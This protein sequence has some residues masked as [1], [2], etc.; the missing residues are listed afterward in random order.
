MHG[1]AFLNGSR[2]GAGRPVGE[3]TAKRTTISPP[4]T[5]ARS[6]ACETFWD[7]GIRVWIG[8]RM[9]GHKVETMFSRHRMGEAPQWLV[10][11]AALLYPKAFQ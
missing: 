3:N 2:D 5:P 8:D 11:E 1:Y 6:T 10:D 9:N 7:D 4:S